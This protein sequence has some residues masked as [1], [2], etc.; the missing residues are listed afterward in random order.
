ML[1]RSSV[2][3]SDAS[4]N[5]AMQNI[6]Y[7]LKNS[8]FASG[9]LFSVSFL[10]SL[11]SD[12]Q[13][14]YYQ[15][16]PAST[17]E[18]QQFND[19]TLKPNNS[20]VQFLWTDFYKRIY[21]ANAVIEGLNSSSG[22]SVGMKNQLTG[23]AKFIR[24]FCHYYLVNIWGDVPLVTTTDY[25]I[26]SQ[27]ARSS[28]TLVYQQIVEDLKAA[29]TLLPADYAFTN[30]ERVRANKWAATALLSRVYLFT[31]DWTNAEAQAT[32]IINNLMLYS[33]KTALSDV[34]LKN[35]NE[36]ILQW[37]SNLRPNDRGT[38]RFVDVPSYGAIN[39]AL[40]NGFESG[41]LR[42]TTWTS[43]TS[44]G[45]Y[46]TLKYNSSTDNPPTQYSTVLRL[47]EQYLIRSEARA[48]QTNIVGSQADINLIRHR[49]GLG[50]TPAN[51]KQSLLLAI[52]QERRVELFNE[53]GHRWFDLKRTNRADAVLGS[54]KQNW[55]SSAVL[56][57]LPEP[58][59]I[60]NASLRDAQNPGY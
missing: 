57:P 34:F 24:A 45:Y 4:A 19:N 3:D 9:T 11:L 15:S 25:R 44:S 42:K 30:N 58:E 56:F 5:A 35:N 37:W 22:V 36:A 52:E 49:A 23:E 43:L 32:V 2:F 60:N 17:A 55:V 10:G 12:E 50:D 7:Q 38:F 51:D 29:Q 27:I 16:S 6:Y 39:P 40:A 48:Q 14:N 28:K 46:R 8:G 1:V 21:D 13:V 33:L 54:V 18:F 26:N 53:W 20:Q 31:G 47:S 41:D 59:M